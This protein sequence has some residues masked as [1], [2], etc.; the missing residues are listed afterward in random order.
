MGS[1][2]SSCWQG[3]K[4]REKEREEKGYWRRGEQSRLQEATG[5]AISSHSAQHPL[6][7]ALGSSQGRP[8]ASPCACPCNCQPLLP[9]PPQHPARVLPAGRLYAGQPFVEFEW[10]VGPI[11]HHNGLGR[12]VVVRYTS[13]L[14]SGSEF[15][16]DANGREMIRRIRCWGI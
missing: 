10:T 16:T 6:C 1:L 4:E 15:W 2:P 14:E 5:R 7:S 11:P 13:D 12:E 3:W 9:A 8:S